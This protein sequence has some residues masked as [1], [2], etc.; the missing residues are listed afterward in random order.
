MNDLSL[1][2]YL[3]T[4]DLP[5]CLNIFSV[6]HYTLK[7]YTINCICYIQQ[8]SLT[9]L[10]HRPSP[11]TPRHLAC[12]R[13]ARSVSSFGLLQGRQECVHILGTVVETK[14]YPNRPP[15]AVQHNSQPAQGFYSLRCHSWGSLYEYLRRIGVSFVHQATIRT[16]NSQYCSP[17]GQIGGT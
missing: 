3:T 11:S 13:A 15:A 5:G 8:C 1:L 7:P 14:P 16:L 2:S 6:H 17:M 9:L 10:H 4:P 12:S